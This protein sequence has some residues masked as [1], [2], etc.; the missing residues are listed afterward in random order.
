MAATAEPRD[1]EQR[2]SDALEHL[3]T[4]SDLWVATAG[5]AEPWLVPLSFHWTGKALLMATLRRNRTCRNLAAGGGARV[6]LGHTRDVVMLDG[7]VDLPE[8]LP[9]DEADA[10][11]VASGYDPRT[12]EETA[13]IRFTP[14]RVQVWRTAEEIEGRT[15][16]RDGRWS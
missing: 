8:D 10:V 12:D 6:A 2:V 16:M 3:G 5:D 4:D 1:R 15:V 11:A 13:Y 14:Q 7:E 9:D